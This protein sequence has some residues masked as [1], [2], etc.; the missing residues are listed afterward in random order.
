MVLTLVIVSEWT[1]SMPWMPLVPWL[2][3]A[4]NFIVDLLELDLEK[5]Y[6]LLVGLILSVQ[7]WLV[8]RVT[9]VQGVLPCRQGKHL[10]FSGV[11]TREY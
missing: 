2:E 4:K 6:L 10:V 7:L 8:T 1:G 3:Y 9:P 5:I 11:A